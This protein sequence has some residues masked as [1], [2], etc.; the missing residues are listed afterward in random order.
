M[1]LAVF[2][3]GASS[4]IGLSIA[5]AF[6]AAGAK[7]AV[8]GRNE[9]VLDALAAELGGVSCPADIADAAAVDRFTASPGAAVMLAALG[10]SIATRA[11]AASAFAQHKRSMTTPDLISHMGGAFEQLFPTAAL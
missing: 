6:A 10:G 11:A 2:V 7:V 3:T 4:G 1:Q 5:K 8:S 9:G